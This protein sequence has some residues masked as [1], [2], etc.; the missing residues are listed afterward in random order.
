M[1]RSAKTERPQ[2]DGE[3]K[4]AGLRREKQNES[5]TDHQ[6][7]CPRTPQPETFRQGL[8]PETHIQE[9]SARERTRVSCVETA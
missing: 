9:V 3:S 2:S 5:P 6:Y 4:A 1:G 8:G 7:Q